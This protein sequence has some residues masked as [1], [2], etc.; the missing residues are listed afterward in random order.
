MAVDYGHLRA[1][2]LLPFSAAVR[3]LPAD[4]PP[5]RRDARLRQSALLRASLR[6]RGVVEQ[7]WNMLADASIQAR[8]VTIYSLVGS[9][10]GQTSKVALTE[11]ETL[12]GEY[13]HFSVNRWGKP[14][15][16]LEAEDRIG[17]YDVGKIATKLRD[18]RSGDWTAALEV[19]LS[20][21]R[22]DGVIQALRDA[23]D[24]NRVTI[25][26]DGETLLEQ[27]HRLTGSTELRFG[28]VR[29]Q[30]LVV[31][32]SGAPPGKDFDPV[33]DVDQR[34]LRQ[35]LIRD[36]DIT[37]RST[38]MPV[39]MPPDI[40]GPEGTLVAVW[41]NN[42][43]VL[44]Y[45]DHLLPHRVEEMTEQLS[46]AV[47]ALEVC[48]GVLR[49][50]EAEI[51]GGSDWSSHADALRRLQY[52]YTYAVERHLPY[53]RAKGGRPIESYY[54]AAARELG[55]VELA[56]KTRTMI[57]R[58]AEAVALS[59]ARDAR[60]TT[61]VAGTLAALL[62]AAALFATLAT[63][64]ST[65]TL[66]GTAYRSAA[67]AEGLVVGAGGIGVFLAYAA[68]TRRQPGA[69]RAR[70]LPGRWLVAAAVATAVAAVLL[71]VAAWGI[72]GNTVGWAFVAGASLVLVGAVA[73]IV[74]RMAF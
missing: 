43:V 36:G 16:R 6:S 68:L 8:L 72:L 49:E 32:R 22:W 53:M 13:C 54:E 46:E 62:A 10:D 48:N 4:P 57:D 29:A 47:I 33:T 71:V 31:E 55:L 28:T 56:A 59:R 51:E 20:A 50:A 40:N 61:V 64:P 45:G 9:Q 52:R 41:A 69:S 35:L 15:A 74:S 7:Q 70:S 60:I 25:S 58:L 44:G 21:S 27:I 66:L 23:Y 18:Y 73:G 30:L 34:L 39:S 5:S 67:L 3:F 11:G 14:Y 63:I 42:T 19:G 24:K 38:W 12:I 1:T 2:R 37:Y 17:Q 26:L 65:N